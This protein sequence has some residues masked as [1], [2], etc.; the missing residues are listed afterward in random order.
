MSWSSSV[1][2][3][4]G[5]GGGAVTLVG[6]LVAAVAASMWLPLE[7][8]ADHVYLCRMPGGSG[9][10]GAD[11]H[12]A[13]NCCVQ[14]DTLFE[15]CAPLIRLYGFTP[16]SVPSHSLPTCECTPATEA[17]EGGGGGPTRR[18]ITT[19][20]T[21]TTA[22]GDTVT[23][24]THVASGP[25]TNDATSSL[26]LV[27][28]QLE[29]FRCHL[30]AAS[31][32]TVA[33]TFRGGVDAGVRDA[34]Y[35]LL[36]SNAT[37]DLTFSYFVHAD[38]GRLSMLLLP[39]PE[40]GLQVHSLTVE[41][42][43]TRGI[44]NLFWQRCFRLRVVNLALRHCQITDLFLSANNGAEDP[45]LNFDTFDVSYN[46]F[47]TLHR[48]SARYGPKRIIYDGNPLVSITDDFLYN[49]VNGRHFTESVEHLSI[50]HAT[51]PLDLTGLLSMPLPNLRVL[52][53]SHTPLSRLRGKDLFTGMPRLERVD[54]SSCNLRVEHRSG[55]VSLV[56]SPA[57][58][59]IRLSDNLLFS[60]LDIVDWHLRQ[61]DLLDVSSNTIGV[62][63]TGD[64]SLGVRV[65]N[66]TSARI[67][68][69]LSPSL[70]HHNMTHLLLSDLVIV[71]R[72]LAP[73]PGVNPPDIDPFLIRDSPSD[74]AYQSS[75]ASSSPQSSESKQGGHSDG[76]AADVTSCS[77]LVNREQLQLLPNLRVVTLRRL[78]ACH[79]GSAP[80]A[81]LAQLEHLDMAYVRLPPARLHDVL[82]SIGA[83]IRHLNLT[84][85]AVT[86]AMLEQVAA[87]WP[88]LEV[89]DISNTAVDSLLPL[90]HTPKLRVL[91]VS[92]TRI[93]T[94]EPITTGQLPL[95]TTLRA[96]NV[97]RLTHLGGA[98]ALPSLPH[99]QHLTISGTGLTRIS[100]N[101][102]AGASN[103]VSLEFS[104]N[105]GLRHV[106]PSL[107]D[108]LSATLQTLVLKFNA[109]P[110]PRIPCDRLLALDVAGCV[111]AT[112]T[113]PDVGS[114]RQLRYLDISSAGLTAL[115]DTLALPFLQVLDISNN[116][117][118]PLLPAVVPR[119]FALTHLFAQHNAIELLSA[120]QLCNLAYV[121]H[122][123][124]SHNRLAYVQDD[125]SWDAGATAGEDNMCSLE[126][127]AL[128]L[129]GN[130]AL[131][132]IHPLFRV[133]PKIVQLDVAGN[134]ALRLTHVQ[135]SDT[136]LR[137]L[138]VLDISGTQ[139]DM[140]ENWCESEDSLEV[141]IARNLRLDV[142]RNT[143]Y[144]RVRFL[145]VCFRH[146]RVLDVSDNADYITLRHLR[147]S[148]GA[149][150]F[151]QV[152][153][154]V[155][156]AALTSMGD[157]LAAASSAA[158]AAAVASASRGDAHTSATATTTTTS[159]TQDA[160]TLASVRCHGDED[161]TPGRFLTRLELEGLYATCA[162]SQSH[163]PAMVDLSFPRLYNVPA[164]EYTCTCIPAYTETRTGECVPQ[165]Q[166][167]WPYAVAGSLG[168][169]AA[170][171]LGL[172]VWRS[173]K[174]WQQV[175]YDLDLR[176]KL[177][178]E[179]EMENLQLREAWEAK[180][181]DVVLQQRI[182]AQSPGTFSQVWRGM[183]FDQVVAVKV[184]N[185]HACGGMLGSTLG[186]CLADVDDDHGGRGG[187]VGAGF[188]PEFRRE[189]E[190]FMT[191]C[192]HKNVVQFL[193]AGRLQDDSPF[194]IL[195]LVPNGSLD[196]FLGTSVWKTADRRNTRRASIA[197]AGL[198]GEEARGGDG[199]DGDGDGDGDGTA[200]EQRR[201][202]VWEQRM[203]FMH[204][205]A[206][207]M[208]HIH[209]K[210]L[211]HRDLKTA[212]VLVS[213]RLEPKITDFG[214]LRTLF[215]DP[216]VSMKGSSNSS[217]KDSR[218]SAVSP[219]LTS[220]VGTPLY[221]A[222]EVLAG[223][224]AYTAAADVWS[225]GVVAWELAALRAPLLL[226]EIG[227]S[228]RGPI[229]AK[230][231]EALQA[232]NRL[233]LD[234]AW[235]E[236]LRGLL[237]RCWNRDWQRRPSFREIARIC[238]TLLANIPP[239]ML[240]ASASHDHL[241]TS[242][243]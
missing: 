15:E 77:R 211:V 243:V 57:L 23:N 120:Q 163:V 75:S 226:E 28:E 82:A 224:G 239:A 72:S 175:H 21:I 114:C 32:R 69:D 140:S 214:T 76:A 210:G 185:K 11:E 126:T 109:F 137:T 121:R 144:H 111:G 184:L 181:A 39:S 64:T 173:A 236:W 129:R 215:E 42:S 196:V 159:T 80:F 93:T 222:P 3:G 130:P 107:L 183:W 151:R 108:A 101:A 219:Y 96:A 161:S 160:A 81:P 125:V 234:E 200:A 113:L 110:L 20:L 171:L 135:A 10:C 176:A 180:A 139:S 67:V 115:P 177:I 133:F 235:P 60:Q 49:R 38:A 143:E 40:N 208:E 55:L 195:E 212:N 233:S 206:R 223:E 155:M 202:V 94:L 116:G 124:L 88:D 131:R 154:T 43:P 134:A 164:L 127:V 92:F 35:E 148:I 158:S 220:A 36:P 203:R 16:Q 156:N 58:R 98:G 242:S 241:N 221:M 209:G 169:V 33:L 95:L 190:F 62:N 118:G 2:G 61:L 31:N 46:Q 59:V 227:K 174:Y 182:D 117:I 5:G 138:R 170:L 178:D 4:G 52:N 132:D 238:D 194:I 9:I 84:S 149:L 17:S 188:S 44:M 122:V 30:S 89:L 166:P 13:I 25:V 8:G 66:L 192:R 22:E 85:T 26:V 153:P 197:G 228:S 201:A 229:L 191:S 123:D 73:I 240:A 41:H 152:S 91:D 150:R 167:Q 142:S 6:L 168:T 217:G 172:A 45:F 65:L 218:P 54:M 189:V 205:I 68:L 232:G 97:T 50:R 199:D 157:T 87:A 74:G 56:S 216:A 12:G 231:Q 213:A 7:V 19:S 18:P 79:F 207:G 198:E 204:G 102:F 179:K 100:D 105:D 83:S 90:R 24:T 237:L 53:V 14:E 27:P 225:F 187:G 106:S 145:G 128:L 119:M 78:G 186:G 29:F 51:G 147:S 146:L 112:A 162:I 193:G 86:S 141:L 103:L 1:C 136:L 37:I 70:F 104:F 48:Q 63:V 165:S 99:L 230:M 71:D 34:I 47:S